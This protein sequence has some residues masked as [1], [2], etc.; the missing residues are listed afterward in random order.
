[1]LRGLVFTVCM[2]AVLSAGVQMISPPKLRRELALIC[3]LLLI[4]SV[5]CSKGSSVRLP[6]FGNSQELTEE[7][8]RDLLEQTR[9]AIED[10]VLAA[11]RERGI[12]PEWLVIECSL[13][14]YNYVRADKVTVY[15]SEEQDEAAA[16]SVVRDTAGDCRIEVIK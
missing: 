1:M 3:T 10:K 13:D 5:A 16:E 7:F 15:L 2:C 9:K 8:R 4:A 6:D 14:E 11:L 12:S